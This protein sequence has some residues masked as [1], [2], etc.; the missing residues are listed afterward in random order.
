MTVTDTPPEAES[1]AAKIAKLLAR[2]E[3][4]NTPEPEADACLAKAQELMTLYAIDQDLV[5]RARGKE[6]SEKIEG[7][8]LR[9]DGTFRMATMRIGWAVACENNCYGYKS[10]HVQSWRRLEGEPQH[11]KLHIF[12]FTSDLERVELLNTSLQ[13]QCAAALRRWWKGVKDSDYK[14]YSGSEQSRVRRQFIFSFAE[15]VGIRLA[16]A[17]KVAET[18]AAKAEAERAGVSEAD[19]AKSVALVVLDRKEQAKRWYDETHGKSTR[20]ANTSYRGGG[21]D[22]AVAGHAA[23]KT[24]NLG[25]TAFGG[26]AKGLNR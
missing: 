17:N 22:A 13:V 25:G 16:A 19:A 4:P 24:A 1:Y 15:G 23:A 12:G 9:F 14:H 26:A 11:I 6:R 21:R 3:H 7:K 5:D 18:E 10:E 8:V 2:A 20:K